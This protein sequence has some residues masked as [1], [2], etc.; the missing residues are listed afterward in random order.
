MSFAGL[1]GACAEANATATAIAVR[2]DQRR[3]K[4]RYEMDPGFIRAAISVQEIEKK[5]LIGGKGTRQSVGKL[6][7]WVGR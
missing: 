1:A 2:I 7:G 3:I 4:A 6:K 5:I